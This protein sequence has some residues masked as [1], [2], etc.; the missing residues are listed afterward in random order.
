MSK[1][2]FKCRSRETDN[3]G[4]PS[5][6]KDSTLILQMQ[7]PHLLQKPSSKM[8]LTSRCCLQL[9]S[10]IARMIIDITLTLK[11]QSLATCSLMGRNSHLVLTH[12]THLK[13]QE[14]ME[15][16]SDKANPCPNNTFKASNNLICRLAHWSYPCKFSMRKR[17]MKAMGKA[18]IKGW[19]L[20]MK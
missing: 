13:L 11:L 14:I 7:E 19:R 15:Q 4:I 1:D 2:S 5:M 16:L 20:K 10:S 17:A 3:S 8:I 12:L 18:H 6:F 9:V